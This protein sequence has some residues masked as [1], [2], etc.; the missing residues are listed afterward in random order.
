[1]AEFVRASYLVANYTCELSGLEQEMELVD[2]VSDRGVEL[3]QRCISL[4]LRITKLSEDTLDRLRIGLD[5]MFREV[6]Y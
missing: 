6:R 3:N 5:Q 1:M 2:S 4:R